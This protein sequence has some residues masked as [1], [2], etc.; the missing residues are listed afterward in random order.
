MILHAISGFNTTSALFGQGKKK[1]VLLAQVDSLDMLDVF[2]NS[3]S[4]KDNI[5]S[6]GEQFL[7]KLYGA[8]MVDTLDK[9]RYTC[10][11]RS[12]SRPI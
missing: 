5:A 12:I 11:S 7:L 8:R 6:A 3:G 2:E 1:A 9:Y 10:Y 4:S